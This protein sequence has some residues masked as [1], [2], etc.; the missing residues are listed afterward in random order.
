[1]REVEEWRCGAGVSACVGAEEGA[2]EDAAAVV[3]ALALMSDA[4]DAA[5]RCACVRGAGEAMAERE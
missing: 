3:L 1:M 5:G 4:G 2:E